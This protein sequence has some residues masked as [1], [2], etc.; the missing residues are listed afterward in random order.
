MKDLARLE[1]L[2]PMMSTAEAHNENKAH[3]EMS[4]KK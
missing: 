1:A 2:F 4:E 3:K